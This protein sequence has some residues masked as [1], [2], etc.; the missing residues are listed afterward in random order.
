MQS[1]SYIC[2]MSTQVSP[3][4]FLFL[5]LRVVG[6]SMIGFFRM[7]ECRNTCWPG[8]TLMLDSFMAGY[9]SFDSFTGFLAKS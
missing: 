7:L 8:S 2:S 6:S 1:Y 5:V 4:S 3:I 9:F